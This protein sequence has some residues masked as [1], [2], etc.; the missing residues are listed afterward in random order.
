VAPAPCESR[1]A[2][3]HVAP[4]GHL[5]DVGAD[6]AGQLVRDHHRWLWSRFLDP[7]YSCVPGLS[8]HGCRRSSVAAAAFAM[9][10]VLNP[11]LAL[12]LRRTHPSAY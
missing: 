2:R 3:Q 12:G 1:H 8:L 4:R 7:E 6:R 9:P 5:Q 10:A 11:T